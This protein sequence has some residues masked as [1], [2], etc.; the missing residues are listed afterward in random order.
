M[1]FTITQF[2]EVIEK[3]NLS[4]IAG[5]RPEEKAVWEKVETVQVNGCEVEILRDDKFAVIKKGGQS[6]FIKGAQ[7]DALMEQIEKSK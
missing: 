5:G 6:K 4:F 1:T 3:Y 2:V 7:F